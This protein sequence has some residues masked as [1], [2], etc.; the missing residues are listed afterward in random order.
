MSDR[1][2]SL[3]QVKGV[4]EPKARDVAPPP[5]LQAQAA[6]AEAVSAGADADSENCHHHKRSAGR[7]SVFAGA[8]PAGAHPEQRG[9]LVG[10]LL[11]RDAGGG[12]GQGNRAAPGQL[13]PPAP[14]RHRSVG[15]LG[16]GR[17]GSPDPSSGDKRTTKAVSGTVCKFTH[18]YLFGV[19]QGWV[20]WS[21]TPAARRG[22]SASASWRSWARRPPRSTPPTSSSRTSGYTRA[23]WPRPPSWAPWWQP[24]ACACP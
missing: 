20:S 17:S 6:L 3:V 2:R 16:A 11:R 5:L 1:T 19:A 18:I 13:G 24:Y 4:E 8:L 15:R 10:A 23:A 12:R 14:H 22:R 7:A 9:W 21:I